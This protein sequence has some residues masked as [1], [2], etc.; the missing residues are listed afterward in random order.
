[1]Y[2]SDCFVTIMQVTQQAYIAEEWVRN[3]CEEVN[4]EAHFRANAEKMLAALK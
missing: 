4:V 2:V 1:M 3:A